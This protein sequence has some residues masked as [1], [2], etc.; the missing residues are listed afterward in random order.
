MVRSTLPNSDYIYPDKY[1]QLPSTNTNKLVEHDINLK[2]LELGVT[3][4]TTNQEKDTDG[5]YVVLR[6]F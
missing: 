5:K 6:L 3:Q 2:A 4:S 1:I